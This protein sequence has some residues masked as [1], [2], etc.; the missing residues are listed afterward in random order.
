MDVKREIKR[1]SKYTSVNLPSLYRY[2]QFRS[3]E[4]MDSA[5]KY[6]NQFLKKQHYETLNLLKQYSCVHPGVSKLKVE[7]M[8]NLLN[9]D[10]RTI[11]RHLKY[12]EQKGY[13]TVIYTYRDKSGG[14]GANI[15][16]INKP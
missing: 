6:Y 16:V 14:N 7:T 13:I 8:A 4:E 1:N 2:S 11:R 3:V 15:Y 9:K 5:V 10:N 12:L